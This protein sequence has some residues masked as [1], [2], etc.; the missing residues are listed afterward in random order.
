MVRVQ[1]ELICS[2]AEAE[3]EGRGRQL[4][5]WEAVVAGVVAVEEQASTA[6]GRT[7]LVADRPER[8]LLLAR[9]GRAVRGPSPVRVAMPNMAAVAVL[10]VQMPLARPTA[11]T[12]GV[13][14]MALAAVA[15]EAI[16]RPV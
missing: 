14:S 7:W 10:A 11:R 8:Q 6:P 1:P 9:P 5:R 15:L 13:R 4:A 3:E 12:G 2:R 16:F